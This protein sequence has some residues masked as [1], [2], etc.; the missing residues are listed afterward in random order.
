M[1]KLNVGLRYMGSG[2][3]APRI[4]VTSAMPM[5]TNWIVGMGHL[6][7]LQRPEPRAGSAVCMGLKNSVK[8]AVTR[9]ITSIFVHAGS[10]LPTDCTQHLSC[11]TADL[12]AIRHGLTSTECP[13]L[14]GRYYVK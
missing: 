5:A 10:T 7:A 14:C 3:S 9:I 11:E 1:S 6:F 4:P 2:R 13:K 8:A 12:L